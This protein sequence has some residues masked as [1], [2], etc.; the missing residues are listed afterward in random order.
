MGIGVFVIII[1]ILKLIPMIVASLNLLKI[2]K[3]STLNG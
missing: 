3:L 1:N 2:I